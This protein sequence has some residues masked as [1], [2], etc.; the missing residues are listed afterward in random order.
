MKTGRTS[1]PDGFVRLQAW[2]TGEEDDQF[3]GGNYTHHVICYYTLEDAKSG[4]LAHP[5]QDT[6]LAYTQPRPELRGRYFK[7]RPHHP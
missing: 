5:P 3:H 4:G 2:R 6:T 7:A 1:V